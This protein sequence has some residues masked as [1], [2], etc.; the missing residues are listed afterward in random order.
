MNYKA[1]NNKTFKKIPQIQQYLSPKE[2][3]EIENFDFN[4]IDFLIRVNFMLKRI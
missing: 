4:K 1:Y 2:I 3:E